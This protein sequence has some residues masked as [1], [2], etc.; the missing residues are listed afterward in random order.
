MKEN[1]TYGQ[2]VMALSIYK[3]LAVVLH[4]IQTFDIFKFGYINLRIG[5]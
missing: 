1:F 4:M 2:T 3:A 5:C